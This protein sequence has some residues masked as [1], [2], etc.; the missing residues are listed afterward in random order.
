MRF[1]TN[2]TWMQIAL[3]DALQ[4]TSLEFI[5]IDRIGCTTSS[6]VNRDDVLLQVAGG[7]TKLWAAAICVPAN[8]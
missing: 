2:H 4:S 3:S 1:F 5:F 8:E 6:L 7:M